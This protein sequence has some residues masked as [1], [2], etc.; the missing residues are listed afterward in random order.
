L[1]KAH[2]ELPEATRSDR[3]MATIDPRMLTTILRGVEK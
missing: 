1:H 2:F 3:P